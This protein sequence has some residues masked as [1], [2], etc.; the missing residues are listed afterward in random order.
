MNFLRFWRRICWDPKPYR[1]EMDGS[2]LPR[3]RQTDLGPCLS[4]GRPFS[5]KNP[6]W[7]VSMFPFIKAVVLN[8][9]VEIC[10]RSNNPFIGVT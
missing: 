2:D 3:I 9:S 10:W 4:W 6:L 1:L 7:C 8:L 5:F